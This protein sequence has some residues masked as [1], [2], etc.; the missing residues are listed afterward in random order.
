VQGVD[1]VDVVAARRDDQVA[2][3][4]AGAVGR[5]TVLDRADEQPLA[6]GEADRAAHLPRHPRRRDRHPEGRAADLLAAG[7]ALGRLADAAAGAE[8]EDQPALAPE[9]VDADEATLQVDQRPAGGPARERGGVLDR[10]PEA[11]PARPTEGP[12]G[13][14]DEAGERMRDLDRRL[15]AVRECPELDQPDCCAFM[16]AL[17]A[18]FASW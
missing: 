4:D 9:Q 5:A 13:G 18:R 10:A 12:L 2:A 11:T 7:E 6:L 3:N 16:R 17:Y 15:A 1:A 8:G 14:G